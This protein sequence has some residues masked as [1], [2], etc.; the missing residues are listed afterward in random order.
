[1]DKLAV[2]LF[3]KINQIQMKDLEKIVEEVR[4]KRDF[5]PLVRELT[6][7][8]EEIQRSGQFSVCIKTNGIIL[9]Y[10]NSVTSPSQTTRISQTNHLALATETFSFCFTQATAAKTRY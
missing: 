5:E 10:W 2:Q 1:M 8:I 9:F 6:K 3:D 4:E 7:I